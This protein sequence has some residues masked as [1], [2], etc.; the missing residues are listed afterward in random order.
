MSNE[1]NIREVLGVK[2]EYRPLF[3][4]KVGPDPFV[5]MDRYK[6]TYQCF[7]EW[8]DRINGTNTR[9]LPKELMQLYEE[10]THSLCKVLNMEQ[11]IMKNGGIG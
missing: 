2:E 8:H 10:A 1:I 4:E 6:I 3:F 5:A 7:K 9:G 11:I